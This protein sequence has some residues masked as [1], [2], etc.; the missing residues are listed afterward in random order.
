MKNCQYCQAELDDK[1]VFCSRCGNKQ[2]E[3]PAAE[4]TVT[5]APPAGQPPLPAAADLPAPPY[6]Y[7]QQPQAPKA[8]SA[9]ALEGKRYFRWLGQGVLGTDEPMHFLFAAIVP[10]LITLF[11]TLSSGKMMNWHAGGFFLLW[12]FN[13]ILMVAMPTAAWLCKRYWLG[14]EM[15]FQGAFARYSSY[16]NIVLPISFFIMIL[17]LAIS[18][19]S[20][21]GMNFLSLLLHLV[22]ILS[23]AAATLTCISGS[24]AGTKKLWLV[25]LALAIVYIILFFLINLILMAGVNWGWGG[26]SYF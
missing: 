24:Q 13:L 25:V 6:P 2:P 26:Y 5:V 10:F 20:L 14:E 4:P 1:A 16:Q 11:Y 9:L 21:G 7:T 8:P 19:T 22:P 23:F 3:A 18:M 17:G 12:F 15:D